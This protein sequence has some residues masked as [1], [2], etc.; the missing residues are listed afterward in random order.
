MR[1]LEW[2]ARVADVRH[3]NSDGAAQLAWYPPLRER[4]E[5]AI[6]AHLKDLEPLFRAHSR[7]AEAIEYSLRL[8]G[9]RMRPV[10]VLEC[11][12]A[13]GGDPERAV[14]AAVAVECVHTFSLIHDDLPAMDDDELR[15]GKPCNHKIFGEAIAILAG[16][17][18]AVRASEILIRSYP[19]ELACSLNRA[20]LDGSLAMVAGQAADIENEERP[21]N[22]ELVEFIHL[23]KTARLIENSCRLG[24][25]CAAADAA[26]LAA[27]AEFG[28]RLGLTFQIT[29]DL[30]DATGSAERLGKNVGKDAVAGKQTAPAAFG[31]E[32]SRRRAAAEIR[33]A[34]EALEPLG[35]NGVQLADLARYVTQRDR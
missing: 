24:A 32:Q 27:V 14:P 34:I 31:V 23:H 6:S 15:R 7:L 1:R 13:C 4:V 9:K 35:E 16:D 19:A 10:L 18:L 11:C 21:P 26:R 33:L 5:R 2:K 25:L 3:E 22:A 30:L 20:L 17:W 8:P 28:R 29:D 12:R